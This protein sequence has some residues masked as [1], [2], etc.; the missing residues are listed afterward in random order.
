MAELVAA[1]VMAGAVLMA[2]I[3]V[4]GMGIWF[5][6]GIFEADCGP[7]RPPIELALGGSFYGGMA[8]A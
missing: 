1:L 6:L 3:A 5:G 8:S 4:A 7:F 2:Y